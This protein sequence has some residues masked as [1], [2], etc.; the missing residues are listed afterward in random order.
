MFLQNSEREQFFVHVVYGILALY[1]CVCGSFFARVIL[2]AQIYR[3]SSFESTHTHRVRRKRIL[4]RMQ[5]QND[6]CTMHGNCFS[7]FCLV[8]FPLFQR[9]LPCHNLFSFSTTCSSFKVFEAKNR[10]HNNQKVCQ[11][12]RNNSMQYIC[13]YLL[14]LLVYFSR[15]SI[16]FT[17]LVFCN[18][19]LFCPHFAAVIVF[20]FVSVNTQKINKIN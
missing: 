12:P 15:G 2:Y 11:P 16:F 7:T 10:R 4:I 6:I 5:K 13:V 3:F 20:V 9:S 8:Y 14:G 18:F 19:F 1:V 17:C